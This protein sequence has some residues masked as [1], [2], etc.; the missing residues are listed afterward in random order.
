VIFAVRTG[1][2]DDLDYL[3]ELLLTSPRYSKHVSTT[4]YD[5]DASPISKGKYY[6]K[7]GVG[8]WLDGWEPV[9]EP[10]SIYIK[11]DDDVVSKLIS[12]YCLSLLVM[13]RK[14]SSASLIV[15]HRR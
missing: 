10:D 6:N 14:I 4:A 3:E 15:I 11:I 2:Q 1:N 12:T 8:T 7:Y 5:V 13:L 9:T